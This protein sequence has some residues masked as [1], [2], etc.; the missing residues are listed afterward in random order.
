MHRLCFAG[1]W[2]MAD[3]CGRLEDRPRRIKAELFAY[4]NVEV[5]PILTDLE[6]AGFICRYVVD[7]LSLIQIVNF[8]KH[9]RPHKAEPVSKLPDNSPQIVDVISTPIDGVSTLK[10][11][12]SPSLDVVSPSSDVV[13][14]SSPVKFVRGLGNGERRTENGDLGMGNG[15]EQAAHCAAE[16]PVPKLLGHYRAGFVRKFNETPDISAGKDAKI[17]RTLAR[18]HGIAT[19]AERIDR[20]LESSD[21][22]V[23]KSGKSIGMLKLCWNRLGP[24]GGYKPPPVPIEPPNIWT[25][26]RGELK[27]HINRQSFQTWFTDTRFVSNGSGRVIVSVPTSQAQTWIAQWY[28]DDVREAAARVTPGLCVEFVVRS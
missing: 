13:S 19:V 15:K 11:E 16:E 25:K 7:G 12:E 24:A 2:L 26:V 3:K 20:L 1:L 18:T 23:V 27:A 10:D 22:F 21:P 14:M 17:I 9:Q 6:H 8:G 5:E 4:E 28:A